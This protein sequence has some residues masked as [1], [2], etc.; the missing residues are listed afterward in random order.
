M[1]TTYSSDRDFYRNYF[2]TDEQNGDAMNDALYNRDKLVEDYLGVKIDHIL[3]GTFTDVMPSVQKTVMSG[4]DE[5]QLA[6]THCYVG[7]AEMATKGYLYDWNNLRYC[8]YTQKWWNQ[9]CIENLTVNGKNYYMV[10]DFVVPDMNCILF[11]KQMVDEYS[12]ENPY[13][14]VDD[15]K[16]TLDKLSEMASKVTS[17]INGDGVFDIN[18]RYGLA[19]PDDWYWCSFIH[20]SGI[21]VVSRNDNG[22]YELSIGGERAVSMVEKLDQLVNRSG[23]TFLYSHLYETDGTET[24]R[25][26]T[27]RCLFQVE[28]IFHMNTQRD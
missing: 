1:F 25:I 4:D 8:D 7:V 24:L 27:G 5:F 20:S 28:A 16:W 12:L 2:F 15:G 14:L 6:L 19:S 13:T 18:D 26:S 11:N 3:N 23:D 10:S 9:D 22:N 21:K 17:D